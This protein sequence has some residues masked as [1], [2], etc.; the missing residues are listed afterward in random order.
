MKGLFRKCRDLKAQSVVVPPPLAH[1]SLIKQLPPDPCKFLT[2]RAK[3]D[4]LFM[5]AL[6]NKHILEAYPI[7]GQVLRNNRILGVNDYGVLAC[8]TPAPSDGQLAIQR[9][10]ML[11]KNFARWICRD[12]W[13]R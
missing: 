3:D 2:W 12:D 9:F 4:H 11:S 10:E 6:F 8:I 5:D 1:Q 13:F 7:E